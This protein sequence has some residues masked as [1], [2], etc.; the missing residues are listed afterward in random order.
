MAA[1]DAPSGEHQTSHQPVSKQRLDHVLTARRAKL[2]GTQQVR[3][4]DDLI[5]ADEADENPN[6]RTIEP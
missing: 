3:A 4:N 2:T 1:H 5:G 6:R